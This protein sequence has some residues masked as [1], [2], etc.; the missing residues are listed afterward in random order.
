MDN[1]SKLERNRERNRISNKK[2]YKKLQERIKID[3]E[4]KQKYLE[5]KK[6][7]AKKY[8]DTHIKP[9]LQT[10]EFKNYQNE[11]FICETCNGKY[12]RANK[13]AHYKTAKHQ[14]SINNI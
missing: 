5:N 7:H 8:Y 3:E 9:K 14:R 2:Y 12:T 10:E 4:L 13:Y 1:N 6:K 11:Q